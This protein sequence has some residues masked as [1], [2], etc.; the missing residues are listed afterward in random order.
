MTQLTT[1]LSEPVCRFIKPIEIEYNFI[2]VKDQYLFDIEGKHFSKESGSIKQSPR[3]FVRY[4]YSESKKKKKNPALFI[5]GTD[6]HFAI[7]SNSNQLISKLNEDPKGFYL[8]I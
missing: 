7:F 1:L 4:K 5:E 6:F 8:Q 2:E 3:A